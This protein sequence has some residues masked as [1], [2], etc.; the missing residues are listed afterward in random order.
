LILLN[1]FYSGII[2]RLK[3]KNS[4]LKYRENAEMHI[5]VLNQEQCTRMIK[6]GS[7][8]LCKHAQCCKCHEN[9]QA[10]EKDDWNTSSL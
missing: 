5:R 6:T 10:H 7:K 8:W 3:Q 4:R 9:M 1:R 2:N